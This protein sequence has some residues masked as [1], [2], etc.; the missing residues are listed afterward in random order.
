MA[1]NAES[2]K[3]YYVKG[4]IVS[5]ANDHY[6]NIYIEDENGY[7]LY[8]YGSHDENWVIYGEMAKKPQVGDVVVVKGTIKKYVNK[9]GAV[10]IEIIE[11]TYIP[12]E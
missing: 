6:G 8:I 10:T 1:D 9:S 5:I 4:K 11:A 3:I 2:D 7:Q 12:Y